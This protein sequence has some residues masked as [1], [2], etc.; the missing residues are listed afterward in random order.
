MIIQFTF[1]VAVRSIDDIETTTKK[2]HEISGVIDQQV[3]TEDM[4]DCYKQWFDGKYYI[5]NI[6]YHV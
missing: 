6:E 1:D 4:T 5:N 3:R 2:I